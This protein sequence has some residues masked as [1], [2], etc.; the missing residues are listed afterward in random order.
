MAP[1][2]KHLDERIT[3]IEA[4]KFDAEI[5]EMEKLSMEELRRRFDERKLIKE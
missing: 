4:G 1:K 3:E 2:S 5:E